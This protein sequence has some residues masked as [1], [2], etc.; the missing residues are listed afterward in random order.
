M[1]NQRTIR[2]MLPWLAN[3]GATAHVVTLMLGKTSNLCLRTNHHRTISVSL[4]ACPELCVNTVEQG[5]RRYGL[6]SLF[7][8]CRVP[9]FS[10]EGRLRSFKG[11]IMRHLFSIFS[12][13]PL[14]TAMAATPPL[15]VSP[16]TMTVGK[17]YTVAIEAAG[18]SAPPA[19]PATPPGPYPYPLDTVNVVATGAG[20]TITPSSPD[21][22]QKCMWTGTL[23]IAQD[24]D[25]TDRQ[26]IL[27]WPS[28]ANID[29]VPLPIHIIPKATGPIPPGLT[30]S[31]DVAWKV[32]S[33]RISADNFG[34]RIT[35]LYYPIE[36]AIGNNSGYDLQL[37]S[38]EFQLLGDSKPDLQTL[39]ADP[40]VPSDSYY[41]VRATL[42]RE[43]QIGMRNTT[44]NIVKA[45]G[46][47][48]TGSAVFFRGSTIAAG[49]HKANFLG[50]TDIFSNPFEKGLEMA[51]PDQTVRQ[52]INLDNHSL[53]DGLIIANNTQIRTVVFVDR[54]LISRKEKNMHSQGGGQS[55]PSK[56]KQFG[57]EGNT[58]KR[59][60]YDPQAVAKELGQL[61]LVGRSIYYLNR[62]SVIA[63]PLGPAP[64]V[65]GKT[66]DSGTQGGP[67]VTLTLVGDALTGATLAS[68]EPTKL[69]ISN[70]LVGDGGKSFT[71]TVDPKVADPKPYQLI[72]T[73][74]SGS[75]SFPFT[76]N[77]ADIVIP[78]PKDP[79]T[80]HAGDAPK[81]PVV[82][83]GTYLGN[84][85]KLETSCTGLNVSL[86]SP[87]PDGNSLTMNISANDSAPANPSCPVMATGTSGNTQTFHITVQAQK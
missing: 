73:T 1:S 81:P 32:V 35:K 3:F 60:D 22:L 17:T 9:I 56:A 43:Q 18:C 66:G 40:C 12:L 71:A 31:V 29:N 16:D 68:S 46:P 20:I 24:A 83:S 77:P 51:M 10:T 75:I 65:T 52:L 57:A 79:I 64:L 69:V 8:Y 86:I 5:E 78:E 82:V 62:V 26:L 48:L 54:E 55:Q 70:P 33:R 47:I 30:P 13:L 4:D 28:S 45:I 53:R 23:T 2:T 11:R 72:L 19:P 74:S 80:V 63:N 21:K 50:I 34:S 6:I 36:V 85:K 59:K 42:E 76:V 7:D 37:A 27:Q 44:I 67:P 41:M 58:F 49:R 61:R 38:V 39:C 87:A 25:A 84:V 14:A 15:T